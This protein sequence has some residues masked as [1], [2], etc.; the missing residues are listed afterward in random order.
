LP[1]ETTTEALQNPWYAAQNLG[2]TG[3]MPWTTAAGTAL[4]AGTVIAI[5]ACP[6][7]STPTHLQLATPWITQ[8]TQGTSYVVSSGNP[9]IDLH[10][11]INSGGSATTV[12]T[13]TNSSGWQVFVGTSSG[14]IFRTNVLTGTVTWNDTTHTLDGVPVTWSRITD[15]SM[16]SSW[17]T[18]VTVHPTHPERIFAVFASRDDQAVWYSGD[19][20]NT[21]A[22]R[23]Q[24]LPTKSNPAILPPLIGASFNPFVDGAAY[25]VTPQTSYY[26]TDYGVSGWLEW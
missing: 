4:T 16:P 14:Q 8:E 13:V 24:A 19:G 7:H 17:V 25:I 20:G 18:R 22:N 15:A 6:F 3:W 11:T 12:E 23:T 2:F 1:K 10:L 21:W 5:S 9:T 26:T